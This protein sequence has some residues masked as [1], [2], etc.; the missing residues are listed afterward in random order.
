LNIL[1]T[2]NGAD[3][4]V[5]Y[6]FKGI[7]HR[8]LRWVEIGNNGQCSTLLSALLLGHWAFFFFFYKWNYLGFFKKTFCRHLSP[9]KLLV[10]WERI[11]EAR[12]KVYSAFHFAN[13]VLA[14]LLV[15]LYSV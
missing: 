7:V 13:M 5:Q 15:E 3:N 11:G 9:N 8:K 4:I 10:M 6:A 2:V 14:P 1:V 12:K